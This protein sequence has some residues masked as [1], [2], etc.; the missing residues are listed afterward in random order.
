MNL[1]TSIYQYIYKRKASHH[2][3]DLIRQINPAGE[4]LG[5]SQHYDV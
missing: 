3:M 1:F 2:P 4:K 5:I